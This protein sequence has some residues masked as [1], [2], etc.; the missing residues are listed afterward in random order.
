MTMGQK[1]RNHLSLIWEKTLEE[2][3]FFYI[4]SHRPDL[5]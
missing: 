2:V 3:F 5:S 1:R 4:L